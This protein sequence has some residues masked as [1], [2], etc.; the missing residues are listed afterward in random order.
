M[1]L[2]PRYAD[3]TPG[4]AV[5]RINQCLKK[6]KCEA[7]SAETIKWHVA[8]DD[9]STEV[10]VTVGDRKPEKVCLDH[11]F[12]TCNEL[13]G[14]QSALE[15][16]YSR[17]IWS[18]PDLKER[19]DAAEM[20]AKVAKICGARSDVVQR[21]TIERDPAYQA[22]FAVRCHSY[23]GTSIRQEFSTS[24]MQSSSVDGILESSLNIM[25]KSMEGLNEA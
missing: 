8:A 20:Y 12:A 24:L 14:L 5:Q 10:S 13:S 3:N 2:V 1:N 21:F 11:Q 18:Q 22:M 4:M 17:F 23:A 6:V 16:L 15:A 7:H 19:R 9:I 25:I